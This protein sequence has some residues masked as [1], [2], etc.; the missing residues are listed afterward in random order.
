MSNWK[1][2]VANVAPL[3]GTALGGPMAGQA[4][5]MMLNRFG[6]SAEELPAFIEAA[7][8]ATTLIELKELDVEFEIAMAKIGVTREQIAAKD[9]DSARDRQV[10]MRDWTP[11]ILGVIILFG[12]FGTLAAFAAYSNHINASALP[13][14]NIMIGAL[15]AM[16]VQVTNYFFGSSAGSKLKTTLMGGE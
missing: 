4:T 14:I 3:L 1:S 12:F 6:V 16:T 5:R 7:D 9:R 10:K 8:P 2:I 15:G 13:V 11:T